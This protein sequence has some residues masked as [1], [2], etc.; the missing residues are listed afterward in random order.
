MNITLRQLQI[1][2]E[3]ARRGSMLQAAEALHLTTPA[4]SMQIKEL[5][6]QVGLTLFDRSTKRLAL[7]KAGQVF[8]GHAKRI[9]IDL[10]EVDHD[11]VRFKQLET[12]VLTVATLATTEHFLPQ[13][14]M[15]FST[16]Y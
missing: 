14:L 12:G 4:V 7:S 13:L 9:M 6:K 15:R 10:Q 16:Q 8:E 3:V 5:E 11:I 1:F 2:M